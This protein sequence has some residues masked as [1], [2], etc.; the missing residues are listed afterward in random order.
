[1]AIEEPSGL[2][3]IRQDPD[4]PVVPVAGAEEGGT[5]AEDAA[6]SPRLLPVLPSVQRLASSSGGWGPTSTRASASTSNDDDEEEE[7]EEEVEVDD[8]KEEG[9]HGPALEGASTSTACTSPTSICW[10]CDESAAARAAAAEPGLKPTLSLAPSQIITVDDRI[11]E[12]DA[13]LCRNSAVDEDA[14][15]IGG[16]DDGADAAAAS[17]AACF[18]EEWLR[19]SKRKW[20]M[21]RAIREVCT[22][23]DIVQF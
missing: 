22:C 10:E 14:N 12:Y 15:N 3:Q 7:E 5:A 19:R 11:E 2:L 18:S 13:D 21:Q 4:L 8:G 20:K 23:R 16:D 9:A 6:P 17:T 1:M